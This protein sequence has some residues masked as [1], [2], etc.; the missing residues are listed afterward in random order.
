MSKNIRM[1][2]PLLMAFLTVPM[3]VRAADHA[4]ILQYHHFGNGL[5]P[6]TS[7]TVERF[8]EQLDALEEN[9]SSVW[10]LSEIIS[11]LK[12]GK[13]LPDMCVGITIDDAYRSVYEKAYPLLLGYNFPA[14]VFVA[15]EGVDMNLKTYLSWDQMREMRKHGIT[16]ASHTHTHP[17]LIRTRKGESIAEW[18]SRV[19]KDII[20]S[21][22]RL[23]SELDIHVDFFAYPYGEYNTR[24]KEIVRELN[25]VAFGQQSGAIWSGSDFA[26]LPRFPVSG[27][28]SEIKSFKTKIRSLALP[29]IS[30][31]PESP[32]LS[33]GNRLPVLRLKLKPGDYIPGS[34]A[35]YVSGQGKVDIKWIDKEK[36]I[37]EAVAKY[38]LPKG[39]SRY[40]FTAIHKDGGRY[41]W[42]S[43]LWITPGSSF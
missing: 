13:S 28:Y 32:I 35:C 23:E 15:T 14:T 36:N 20:T 40:N 41:Y 17:Y 37:F 7:V 6:S 34:I 39:R 42:Y 9:N 31:Q 26:A 25:L 11:Y 22:K 4:V 19:K 18:K 21:V 1:Y 8:K 16:F 10:S 5:P 29:V 27:V 43:H 3:G 38:P 24:L 33:P 30:E 12:Q 2:F